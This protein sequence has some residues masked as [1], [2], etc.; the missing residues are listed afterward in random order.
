M[1]MLWC[2]FLNQRHFAFLVEIFDNA[3]APRQTHQMTWMFQI[4]ILCIWAVSW[5]LLSFKYHQYFVANE[6]GKNSSMRR[7]I[8][9][10]NLDPI[11][12]EATFE[13]NCNEFSASPNPILTEKKVHNCAWVSRKHSIAAVRKGS[14]VEKLVSF[15]QLSAMVIASGSKALRSIAHGQETVQYYIQSSQLIV[16]KSTNNA[17]ANVWIR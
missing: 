2:V 12:N 5:M 7:S 16:E 9:N 15:L 4:M 13:D 17:K 11:A 3:T 8:E 1:Y 14:K 6:A 10:C